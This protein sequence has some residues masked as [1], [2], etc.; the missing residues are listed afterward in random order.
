MSKD[1]NRTENSKPP[2]WGMI[3]VAFIL[4]IAVVG[5]FFKY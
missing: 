2:L 5:Y 4:L 3:L 1:P